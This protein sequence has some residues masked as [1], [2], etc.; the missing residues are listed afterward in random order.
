[1]LHKLSILFGLFVVLTAV[2]LEA[3]QL[4]CSRVCLERRQCGKIKI[5]FI[6][7]RVHNFPH[8]SFLLCVPWVISFF[9]IYVS[10]LCFVM[11]FYVPW[12]I[13]FFAFFCVFA[14][15]FFF[16]LFVFV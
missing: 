12:V 4:G 15:Y 9:T 16:M 13:N 1:M 6:M 3:S 8:V 14:G 5:I 11:T 7:S 10:S 2:H